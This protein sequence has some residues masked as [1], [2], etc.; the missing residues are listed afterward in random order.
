M[1]EPLIE[2]SRWRIHAE[3]RD[4]AKARGA[5]YNCAQWAGFKAV[6]AAGLSQPTLDLHMCQRPECRATNKGD[7]T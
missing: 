5:C 7:R 2:A 3:A 4:A 1:T 6:E